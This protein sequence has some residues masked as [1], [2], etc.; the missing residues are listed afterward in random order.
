MLIKVKTVSARDLEITT[1]EPTSTIAELKEAIEQSEG[2]LPSQQKLI[3]NGRP[4]RDEDTVEQSKITAGN[5]VHMV[6]ALRAGE[7]H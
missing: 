2:I 5:T 6:L 3:F 1:C 4:L 7:A